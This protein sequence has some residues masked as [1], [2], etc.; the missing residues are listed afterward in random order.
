M[1]RV[2]LFFISLFIGVS[3]FAQDEVLVMGNVISS[4]DDSPLPG[5][6]IFVFKTVAAGQQEYARALEMFEGGYVPEGGYISK[7]NMQDGSFEFNAQ[8][9]GSL[10][11]YKFPFKPVYVKIR[12]RNKIPTVTIEA[13]TVLDEAMLEEEGVKKTRKGKPV[14]H[15][16]S[17]KINENYYFD[18]ERMGEVEG[19]GKTNSRLV[20]QVFIVN[21]DGTDTL[22]YFPPRVHD[23]EQFHQTQ[24][25]WRNDYLYELADPVER[26]D[27]KKDSLQ[28]AVSF[29][30]D[31][32]TALYYVKA[33]IWIEDYIKVYYR[34]SVTLFN[35]GRVSRPFQFLEYSFDQCQV[36]PE[37]YK[38]LPKREQVQTPKNMKLQFQVGK[39]ELD[40][41]DE[42]TMAALDSLKEELIQICN[43]PAATLVDLHFKGYA[44]PDGVYEKNRDLS[45]RRTKV[46][47]QE[48]EAV[49]PRA[50]RE[51]AFRTAKGFVAPWTDVADI[52]EKDSLL[53]E[54]AEIRAIV[55]QNPGNMDKQGALIKRL[56]YYNSKIRDVLPALRS[57]KCEHIAEVYRFLTPEEIL[58]KYQTDEGFRAGRKLMTLNEYWNLFQ[59]VNDPKELESLYIRGL[60]AAIKAE[61]EP[62]ALPAN[63][64]AV[65][66]LKRKQMDT[67]ILQPFIKEQ[68]GVNFMLTDAKDPNVKRKYNDDAIV[69]NQVQMFMLAK[70]YS[71]A[72]EMT[73]IIENE[74]PKLRAIVR[75]LGGFIDFNDPAEQKT[76]EIIKQS[77]PRN[78]VIIDLYRFDPYD[79]A[80][81]DTLVVETVAALQKLPQDQAL[82]DYL[83]VQRFCLQ[84]DNDVMKM[85]NEHFNREEDPSFSHPK[86]EIIPPP[87]P[88]DIEQ[89]RGVVKNLE[90][91]IALF[92]DM[93]IDVSAMEPELTS[94]R[95]LLEGMRK[96]EATLV[97]YEESSVY[98]AAYI[99]LKRCFER[100]PKMIKTA[101]ADYDI[102][103]DLLNDVLG[104]KKEKK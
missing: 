38:K 34:D 59:L 58:K 103:E 13:T 17:F 86:D 63:N 47:Q 95:N 92:R 57:V 44:S 2:L 36:N 18:K 6:E 22:R 70:K 35:T 94:A 89:Q 54:A 20:S 25:H 39:A 7:Y 15:G 24:V 71:R 84:Y 52:L 60:A 75:C 12:G 43:D 32:P 82:T 64:L 14:A 96:G 61:R 8:A 102:A 101:Q 40:K 66:Y 88:E 93:G 19:V 98:E 73:S 80:K 69:A 78:E 29:E 97:P 31:D 74:H 11:F 27:E 42:A 55:E 67:T 49:L 45:D 16:N 10:I 81:M 77:S 46:V 1:K 62:W 85:R 3:A 33:N 76:V 99:Y 48:V 4:V 23:G 37:D 91:E 104:I 50:K 5:V 90:E 72:E 83:K 30:V 53:T 68:F 65:T 28:F 26:F 79:R 51:R 100:D 41:S 87:S 9:N 21:S 56:P